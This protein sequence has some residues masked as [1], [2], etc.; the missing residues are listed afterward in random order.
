[1]THTPTCLRL[2]AAPRAQAIAHPRTF[3]R[4]DTCAK[5]ARPAW[6]YDREWLNDQARQH[7]PLVLA[8]IGAAPPFVKL[9]LP[10]RW[11]YPQTSDAARQLHGLHQP[12]IL[13]C[14]SSPDSTRQLYVDPLTG[15]WHDD[16]AAQPGID[17]LSLVAFRTG[18]SLTKAAWR[19]AAWCGLEAPRPDGRSLS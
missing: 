19:L 18:L 17:L 10:A 4:Q 11:H 14:S 1:M 13:G 8:K 16:E 12:P 2:A 6:W 9:P 15:Y 3:T 5:A 7:L